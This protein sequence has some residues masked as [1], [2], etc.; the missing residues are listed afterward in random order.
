[1]ALL[2]A[3]GVVGCSDDGGS[4]TGGQA[5]STT[6]SEDTPDPGP[7]SGTNPAGGEPVPGSAPPGG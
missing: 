7:Q 4:G 3:F 5:P 1:V 2:L 6:R